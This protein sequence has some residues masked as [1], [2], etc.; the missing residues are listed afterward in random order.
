MKSTL[1]TVGLAILV[2]IGF[3][4]GKKLYLRPKNIAGEKA[5]DITGQLPDGTPFTLS[6]LQGSYILLDFWGSWCGPCRE[7]HPQLVSLYSRYNKQAFK[8]A[9]GFEIVSVGLEQSRSNWEG[10]IRTDQLN[11]PYHLMEQGSFD[12]PAVKAYGVKQI[13][14]TFL[15]NPKGIMMAVDPSFE[16]IAKLLEDRRK[17]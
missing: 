17:T 7:T 9:K 6:S 1:L 8:D 16:E 13:P 4:V 2:L 3:Q 11:W 15:I 10:A 5:F 12:S 14:T